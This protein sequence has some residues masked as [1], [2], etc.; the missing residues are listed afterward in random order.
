MDA[1]ELIARPVEAF[2]TDLTPILAGIAH[3]VIPGV[4]AHKPPQDITVEAFNLVTAF[5][6]SDSRQSDTELWA[7]LRTFAPRMPTQLSYASPQHVR[8][9]RLV[10]GKR[11]WLAAPSLLF[12]ILVQTDTT[13]RTRSSWLYYQRAMELAHAVCAIDAVPSDAELGALERY[14]SMLLRAIDSAGVP[15]PGH[16]DPS[17]TA[18]ASGKPTE[19]ITGKPQPPAEAARPIEDLI[20]ELDELIGLGPVKAEV[21]L[22][23]N[24]I[25]V[26]KLRQER[27]LP[28]VDSSRHMIFTGNPGTGKTT[29]ARL[30]AQIF[31]TLGVVQVGH[32]V[33]TDR[34]GLVAGYV[35]QTALKV[36]E[37]FDTAIGGVLL[38]DEAY[39]LARGGESDFGIEATDTLVK[40]IEDHRDEIVVIAAGYPAEMHTF[41]ESNPGLRSRFPKTIFF[42]DYTT[43]ELVAIFD[44]L[45]R[46]TS[47]TL[48]SD[49]REALRDHLDGQARDK[50]F[51][52][53]RLVRNIFEAALAHQAT[54]VVELP[55]PTNE[56]LMALE[57]ADVIPPAGHDTAD[58]APEADE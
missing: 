23:T 2:V 19:G 20:A 16:H 27:G 3:D 51:G 49:A 35:G 47:Y 7:L 53:G 25:R 9:A 1:E 37:V 46:K 26:Q 55:N 50:G 52:N 33:E 11:A 40:L 22:V 21:K 31:R 4:P 58:P 38:I 15:R 39:A 36:R 56:Q 44:S 48:T 54:R 17:P 41:T 28:I 30:L 42:P 5:I 13:R 57:A 8:G 32:L 6:D 34:S 12:D 24:L 14:R 10:E 45:C 18:T 29:V 43:G